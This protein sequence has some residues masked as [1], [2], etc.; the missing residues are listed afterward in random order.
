MTAWG[1]EGGTTPVVS[2]RQPSKSFLLLFLEKEGLAFSFRSLGLA[3]LRLVPSREK[4]RVDCCVCRKGSAS[5][6]KKRSKKL[7]ILKGGCGGGVWLLRTGSFSRLFQR[8][9]GIRFDE[10][11][12][13]VRQRA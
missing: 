10:A 8:R 13:V 5:F 2:P 6:L 9:S 11:V 7:L 3:W 1:R 4:Y 12:R